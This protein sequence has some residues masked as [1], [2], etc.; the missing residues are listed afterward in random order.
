MWFCWSM[1]LLSDFPAVLD[2]HEEGVSSF[3]IGFFSFIVVGLVIMT[4]AV[5]MAT[6]KSNA[7]GVHFTQT[8]HISDIH[9]HI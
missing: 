4:A 3:Y 2:H 8:T 1:Y 5:I 6:F 7:K 9:L